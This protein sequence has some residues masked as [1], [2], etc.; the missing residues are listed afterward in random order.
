MVGVSKRQKRSA[1]REKNARK[2]PLDIYINPER[3]H[4]IFEMEEAVT[5][6]IRR[7]FHNL[8]MTAVYPDLF[9][10][11]WYSQLPCFPV[12]NI[13]KEGLISHCEWAGQEVDCRDIFQTV[14]T[15]SGM[16]CTFNGNDV[17]KK[18][19]YKNLIDKMREKSGSKLKNIS[20]K[21]II[22]KSGKKNGLK[23]IL[24]A[25][26][27]LVTFGSVF[28]D[29]VGMQVF[30]GEP[31]EFVAMQ[32]R[33]KV[34]EPGKEH[35]ME[36][37]GYVIKADDNLKEIPPKNRKCFFKDES[38]LEYYSTYTTTAC[39]LE[40]SIQAVEQELKCI[41]WYFPQGNLFTKYI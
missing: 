39:K 17:L 32:E 12:A 16:C 7:Y 28:D 18:S 3:Q 23:I 37:T 20:S 34:L 21:K 26:S 40:C 19:G 11:L 30:V 4:E 38:T 15:D 22:P 6:P 10:L 31:E 36:I 29:M 35:F 25:H 1:E 2:P 41:P 13:S 24:D 9:Q 33:G 27:N 14:A 5:E 8:N